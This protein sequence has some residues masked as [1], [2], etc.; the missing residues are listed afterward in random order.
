[1]LYLEKRNK[2]H[3]V[4]LGIQQGMEKAKKNERKYRMESSEKALEPTGTIVGEQFQVIPEI[5]WEKVNAFREQLFSKQS[6]FILQII[7]LI[8]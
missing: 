5:R 6:N 3:Q 1:M 2:S 4:F 8:R 7:F